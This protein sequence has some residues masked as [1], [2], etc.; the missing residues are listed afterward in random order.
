[1]AADDLI[2]LKTHAEWCMKIRKCPCKQWLNLTAIKVEFGANFSVVRVSNPNQKT[3][4]HGPKSLHEFA[5]FGGNRPAFQ[6][7]TTEKLAPDRQTQISFQITRTSLRAGTTSATTFPATARTAA[8]TSAAW[9]RECP[10]ASATR[11]TGK[12]NVLIVAINLID[13]VEHITKH[14]LNRTRPL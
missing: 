4:N 2:E 14:S 1:M 3:Q 11:A 6:T 13:L 12:E 9:C 10:R 7:R 5:F 8:T